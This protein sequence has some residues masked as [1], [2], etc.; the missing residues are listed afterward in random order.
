[1]TKR[2]GH[3]H[4]ANPQWENPITYIFWLQIYSAE[5]GGKNPCSTFKDEWHMKFN[6]IA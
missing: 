6:I 3:V 1:M 4:M 2:R 5:V